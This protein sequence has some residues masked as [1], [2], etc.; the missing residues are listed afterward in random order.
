LMAGHFCGAG[1]SEL[2]SLGLG[3][4]AVRDFPT[5]MMIILCFDSRHLIDWVIKRRDPTTNQGRA[6]L[7]L[8]WWVR[9]LAQQV[10]RDNLLVLVRRPRAYHLAHDLAKDS[11]TRI[12][13]S[14]FWDIPPPMLLPPHLVALSHTQGEHLALSPLQG[15]GAFHAGEV[16]V[17]RRSF[18][19]APEGWDPCGF[20]FVRPLD[21]VLIGRIGLPPGSAGLMPEGPHG[22]TVRDENEYAL[23][24]Y[25]RLLPPHED[26][27]AGFG[28]IMVLLG[29]GWLPLRVL[30]R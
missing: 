7:H 4:Q 30:S 18:R 9:E 1:V 24:A 19:Y 12:R 29:E 3:L 23:W 14:R 15:R 20:L 25:A 6:N 26:P 2:T 17:V 10:L 5:D 21:E 16:C 8:I 28:P 13:D 22:E 27:V 11:M